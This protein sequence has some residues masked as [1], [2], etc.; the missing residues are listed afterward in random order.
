MTTSSDLRLATRIDAVIDGAIAAER[1]VG[2]VTLIA[3]DGETIHIRA[4]G[5]ADREAGVPMR[6][7]A[8]FRFA[9]VSK[10]FT[11]TAVM[12]LVAE[13]RLDLDRPVTDWLPAFTPMFDGTPAIITLRH[14]LSHRAGLGYGFFEP[15]DGPL[16]PAGVSDGMGRSGLTLA[17]NIRRLR[18]V[19]LRSSACLNLRRLRH[20]VTDVSS[21]SF[22]AT[23]AVFGVNPSPVSRQIRQLEHEL[24]IALFTRHPSGVAPYLG[25][26]SLGRNCSQ[27][28]GAFRRTWQRQ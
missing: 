8:I 25:R 2:A 3:R 9:S 19:I 20:L 11:A 24:G 1:I 7:D 18:T 6:A 17:E 15:K 13:R 10:L 12:A 21:G 22:R 14:L 26:P 5:I 16:H 4:A 28:H 27:L 23:A